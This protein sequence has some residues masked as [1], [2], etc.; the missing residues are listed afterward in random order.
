MFHFN[1]GHLVNPEIPM[2]VLKVK[3]QSYYVNHVEA[4]VG[5][6]TKESP[7]NPSTKGSLKFKKVNVEIKDGDAKIYA[8]VA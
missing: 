5:F 6:S 7:D 2:W 4:N 1:K 3:G 8:S